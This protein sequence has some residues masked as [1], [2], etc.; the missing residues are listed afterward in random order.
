MTNMPSGKEPEPGYFARAISDE[1]SVAMARHRVS[2]TQLARMIGRSQS[3]V[4]KRLNYG[5]AFTANDV[6]LI[7]EVMGEDLLGLLRSAVLAAKHA[8]R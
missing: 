2:G 5:A 7:S 6:E 4:S 3:Y 1:I 8:K